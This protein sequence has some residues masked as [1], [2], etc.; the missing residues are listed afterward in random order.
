MS[1]VHSPPAAGVSLDFF[2][3]SLSVLPSFHPSIHHPSIHPSIILPSIH[4]SI[5]PSTHPCMHPS[6]CPSFH[7]SIHPIHA[8]FNPCILQSFHPFFLPF[9]HLPFLPAFLPSLSS[10]SSSSLLLLASSHQ[11]AKLNQAHRQLHRQLPHHH[12]IANFFEPP[13]HRHSIASSPALWT[14]TLCQR[15]CNAECQVKTSGRTPEKKTR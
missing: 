8:S 9:V 2:K 10:S 3:V 7:P 4:P 12:V 5:H 15:K 13:L 14:R 1:F 11:V 6:I